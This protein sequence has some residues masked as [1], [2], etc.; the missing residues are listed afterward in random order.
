MKNQPKT[1]LEALNIIHSNPKKAKTFLEDKRLTLNEKKILNCWF[2]LKNCKH[3]EILKSLKNLKVNDYELVEGQR[4]LIIGI[5]YNNQAL[6]KAAV[7]NISSAFEILEKYSLPDHHFTAVY[8]LFIAHLNDCNEAGMEDCLDLMMGIRKANTNERQELC[9]HHAQ[10]CYF[11][12]VENFLEAEKLSNRLDHQKALMSDSMLMGYLLTKFKIQVKKEN[13]KE[14]EKELEEIK[15][16]RLFRLS[17]GFTFMRTALDHLLHNKPLYVYRDDFKDCD[18]L[19]FHLKVV[20]ALEEN[21]LPAA[22]KHWS[23]LMQ[24]SP[25][26]YHDHFSYQGEKNLFAL[27]LKRHQSVLKKP[28]IE[29][30]TPDFSSNKS[31]ALIL[32][33]QSSSV[34]LRKDLVFSTLWGSEI[35]SEN[36]EAKIRNLISYVRKTKNI[37]ISFRV[38]IAFG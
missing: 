21:D 18:F 4:L 1:F 27:C 31:E 30:N 36:D 15:K 3:D 29:T 10:F 28:V 14:A 16:Y 24:I 12:H 37:K 13:L 20:Q 26:L 6:S 32:L 17:S 33:L 35:E 2:L 23:E 11:V 34:P 25:H 8:N 9:F 22:K 5:T 38:F 19:Y 7:E